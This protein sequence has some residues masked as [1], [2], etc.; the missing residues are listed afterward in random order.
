MRRLLPLVLMTVL[1]ILPASC[2][3][4]GDEIGPAPLVVVTDE[5]DVVTLQPDGSGVETVA[6]AADG[7]TFSQPTWS[8]D[9]KSLAWGFAAPDG[10]GIQVQSGDQ[11]KEISTT[12]P[13]FYL[14]WAPDASRLGALHNGIGGAIDFVVADIESGDPRL[15]D[16]GAPFYYAWDPDSDSVVAHIAGTRFDRLDVARDGLEVLGRS[17]ADYLAPFVTDAGIVHLADDQLVLNDVSLA[18]VD[19]T[20]LFVPNTQGTRLAVVSPGEVVTVAETPSI[21]PNRLTV[22]DVASGDL[23]TLTTA[24]VVGFFWSPDGESLLVLVVDGSSITPMVWRASLGMVQYVGFRPAP[25]LVR[26][27]LPFF[28]QYAQS[29]SF[30]SPDGAAFAYPGEV[31]GRAGIWVQQVESR[32]PELIIDGTWVSWSPASQ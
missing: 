1:L 26:D 4:G 25:S 20:A 16:N 23:E 30:W 7:A 11:I 14:S 2:D 18:T 19:G 12:N 28:P 24:Q 17:D 13:V 3:G 5:G 9:G 8:P 29:I 10:T 32:A 6:T 27:V 22:I 31:E 21:V 15:V